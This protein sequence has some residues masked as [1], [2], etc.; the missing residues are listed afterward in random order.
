MDIHW[1]LPREGSHEEAT[2]YYS[3]QWW[4]FSPSLNLLHDLQYTEE[5]ILNSEAMVVW[6]GLPASLGSS[7]AQLV[8]I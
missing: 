5:G 7:A 4:R 3:I 6:G 2:A 8:M 1:A